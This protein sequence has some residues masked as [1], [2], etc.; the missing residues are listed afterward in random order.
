MTRNRTNNV[1]FGIK[2]KIVLLPKYERW[3]KQAQ[4]L[5]LSKKARQRLEWIIYQEIKDNVR[6]TCRHFD[7]PPKTFYKWKNRFNGKDLCLLEDQSKAPQHVRQKEI[8]SIQEMRI[9][10]LRKKHIRWGKMKLKKRYEVIYKEHISSW[11]I[12]YTIEK[13][14]L[15]YHPQKNKRTQE[16]RLKTKQKKRITEL[17]TQPFPGFLLALDTIVIHYNGTK[18]YILTAIDTVSKIAFAR[19]Y[20]TK[21]SRNAGDFLKRVYLLMDGGILNSLCDNGSE[22]HKE[23]IKACSELSINQYWSRIHTPKDNPMCERFNRTLQEEFIDL[24]NYTPDVALFNHKL[25]EWIIEYNM[26]RPHQSLGYDTPWEMY[27]TSPKIKPR[28]VLNWSEVLPMYP[29]S[30]PL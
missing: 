15:Y 21:S 6:L 7:I 13:Y 16:K 3:R 26:V 24:G 23:F 25:T 30:T 18:R 19:M 29:S 20:T 14:Q 10:D 17:K 28:N 4:L 5:N 12:Q 8:T 22:F 1:I 2:K 27:S 11:K 9:T